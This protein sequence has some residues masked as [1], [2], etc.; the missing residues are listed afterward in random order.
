MEA[1]EKKTSASTSISDTELGCLADCTSH[2][3]DPISSAEFGPNTSIAD[4][5]LAGSHI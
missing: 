2:R 3:A 1:L 5:A 4:L